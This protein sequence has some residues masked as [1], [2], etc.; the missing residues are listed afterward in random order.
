MIRASKHS[1]LSWHFI[2]FNKTFSRFINFETKNKSWA[3]NEAY[4]KILKDEQKIVISFRYAQDINTK[5][6]DKIFNFVRE[7]NENI[8]VSLNRIKNNIEKELTKKT[9]KKTKKNQEQ[10]EENSEEPQVRLKIKLKFLSADK[11]FLSDFSGTSQRKWHR[12]QHKIL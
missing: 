3:M 9:K 12:Q 6:V 5:K 1:S 4:F 10:V 11:F 7:L 8:E 2:N